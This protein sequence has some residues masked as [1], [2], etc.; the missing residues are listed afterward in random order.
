MGVRLYA[1]ERSLFFIFW[2]AWMFGYSRKPGE[3]SKQGSDMVSDFFFFFWLKITSGNP[4]VP[5]EFTHLKAGINCANLGAV[6]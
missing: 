2:E 3:I 4:Q 1:R 6:F 5:L